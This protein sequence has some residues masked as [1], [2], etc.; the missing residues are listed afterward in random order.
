[1]TRQKNKE[2][3]CLWTEI[4]PGP[5]LCRVHEVPWNFR[6]DSK[7]VPYW[8]CW[9]SFLVNNLHN[10][11]ISPWNLHGTSMESASIRTRDKINR[12]RQR[13][14]IQNTRGSCVK[15]TQFSMEPA[16]N[17]HGTCIKVA[18]IRRQHAANLFKLESCPVCM[19]PPGILDQFSA[20]SAWKLHQRRFHASTRCRY[21]EHIQD[22][23]KW[24]MYGNRQACW[25]TFI[26][27]K[28]R[29]SVNWSQKRTHKKLVYQWCIW[30]HFYHVADV[31]C[32]FW[33][34]KIKLFQNVYLCWMFVA[35]RVWVW[36]GQDFKPGFSNTSSR[37]R[38]SIISYIA[39]INLEMTKKVIT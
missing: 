21:R 26:Y 33:A 32:G 29:W 30:C 18:S 37:S 8:F 2:I 6:A 12:Y 19:K 15:S 25:C 14:Y 1:M 28:N 27:H 39:I 3:I 9:F 38:I 36:Q 13:Q 34:G 11:M 4:Q 35:W 10:N 31:S 22:V 23:V 17:L 20:E 5:I 16:W 7:L 24:K